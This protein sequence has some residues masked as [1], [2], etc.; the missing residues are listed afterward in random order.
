MFNIIESYKDTII[1]NLVNTCTSYFFLH[2]EHYW[3]VCA[4]DKDNWYLSMVL[5]C[6]EI[7]SK[8]YSRL[9]S[10]PIKHNKEVKRNPYLNIQQYTTFH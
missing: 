5:Y 6:S 4:F 2:V 1:G 9:G 3:C 10:I 8:Y 7:M